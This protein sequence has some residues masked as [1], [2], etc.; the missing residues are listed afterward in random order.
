MEANLGYDPEPALRALHCPLFAV[1]GEDDQV[2]DPHESA[3]I[4]GKV[5]DSARFPDSRAKIYAHQD[6]GVAVQPDS[7]AAKDVAAW[8]EKVTAT[9]P[10]N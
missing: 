8:I 3:A 10:T 5:L 4:Y 9:K 2:V 1:L 6:H 7:E